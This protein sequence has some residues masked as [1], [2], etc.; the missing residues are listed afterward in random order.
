M[1]LIQLVGNSYQSLPLSIEQNTYNCEAHVI[2]NLGYDFVL[3]RDFLRQ[4]KAV[5]DMGGHSLR[6][7]KDDPS[8]IP[9]PPI[10]CQVRAQSTYVIPV[11]PTHAL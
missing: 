5:I 9:A 10:V 7:Q 4:N 6:L 2:E 11:I 3:G 1:L 8:P